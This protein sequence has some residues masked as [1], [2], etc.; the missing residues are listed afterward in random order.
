[1]ALPLHQS[2]LVAPKDDVTLSEVYDEWSSDA[3][4]HISSSLQSNYKSAYKEMS[5]LHK[6]KFIDIRTAHLQR[7]VDSME[8]SRSSKQKVKILCGLLY[9]YAMQNDIC[10]KNYAEFIR[11]GKNEKS[12]KAIFTDAE[13]KTLTDNASIEHVDTILILIY[14]GMR[15]GEMLSLTK[16]SIDLDAATITGGLKTDAG[17]NRIIP[18]SPKVMQ[19]IK[20]RYDKSVGPLFSI[21]GKNAIKYDYYINQIYYPLL[22]KLGLPRKTP[23]TARHT[24]ATLLARSG[25]DTLAI[26]QVLGHTQYS[27]TA[28]TYTHTDVDFLRE[29]VKKL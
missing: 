12:E 5:T 24:C 21:D 7:I 29:A 4:K 17:K 28:D 19:Y 16:F 26:Q 23:H 2:A 14:T 8:K 6:T 3:F 18:I 11:L 20:G 1:M 15:I 13:I 9:K 25:A 10:N 27:F 22:E